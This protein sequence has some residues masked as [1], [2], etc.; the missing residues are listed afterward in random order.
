MIVN[1][2]AIGGE[3]FKEWMNRW[4]FDGILMKTFEW[5]SLGAMVRVGYQ[6]YISAKERANSPP[7]MPGVEII[8]HYVD[9]RLE[10]LSKMA[11][12]PCVQELGLP[13][14]FASQTEA[15]SP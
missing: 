14:K 8:L 13:Y 11:L 7:Y 12:D 6:R 9:F 5:G 15:D 3:H 4:D 10:K 1:F 2:S